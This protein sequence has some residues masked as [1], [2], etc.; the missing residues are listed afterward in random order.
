M[1]D[2]AYFTKDKIYYSD[3]FL[4]VDLNVNNIGRLDFEL[5]ND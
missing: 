1:N 4:S 2:V 5:V 3:K